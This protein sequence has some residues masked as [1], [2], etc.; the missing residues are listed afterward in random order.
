MSSLDPVTPTTL[1]P[2]SGSEVPTGPVTRVIF[3]SL[4]DVQGPILDEMRRIRDRA[5]N[6]NATQGIRVALLYL[7]GAFVEWVE[8]P[9]EGVDELLARVV[10]DPHHHAMKVVHR[11]IGRPRLY[12]PWIGSIVQSR[13]STKLFAQRVYQEIQRHAAAQVDE[14]AAV[15]WRLSSPPALDMPRPLGRNSRAM[16][17]CAQGHGVFEMLAWVA[18]QT[19]RTLVCRRFAGGAD[20]APDVES[21][22]VDLPETG[23]FGWR[24]I[25]NARKGLAMGMAHAFLPD[26]AAAVVVLNGSASRNQRLVDRVIAACQ[27]VHHTPV[28]VA[29]GASACVTAALQET[30][31][32][33]GFPW[34]AAPCASDNPGWSEQWNALEPALLQLG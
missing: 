34:L 5:L 29:L 9:E 17:L 33:Q 15:W 30:A 4:C 14:P 16:M 18:R 28:I 11:S 2:D 31:E 7:C 23:P 12:R 1:W 26:Y 22:Y 6:N 24:L 19:Q 21:D 25:A 13:E 8:G 3:T 27:Q 10:D 20:E 32:R